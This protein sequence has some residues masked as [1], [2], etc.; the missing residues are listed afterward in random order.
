MRIFLS[1]ASQDREMA[2]SIYL[3]LRDQRHT[4]FFDRADLPAGDEYHNRI[5]S[6]IENSDL[7]MFLISANAVDAGSYTLTELSI[8]EKALIKVLPVVLGNVDV[9][10]LPALLKAV[11]FFQTDGNLPAAVAAEVYRIAKERRRRRLKYLSAA[12]VVAL[13]VVGGVFYA[14]RGRDSRERVGK[15]GAS[16]VL[17][18][19]GA[20]LGG[21]DENS[22]RRELFVEAFYLDRYEVT[23]GRYARFL[24]ATGNVRP[25]EEWD[26]VDLNNGTDLPVIGVDWQDA[27]SYCQW[28]GR[29]L[30]TDAEWERAARG[31][32]ERK[33]PWGNEPP[34]P[35]H[36]RFAQ[37]YEKAVY[38]GGVARVGSH[39]KGASPFGI[40]DMAGNA[41][42]WTADWFSES[43]PYADRR[44]PKGPSSGTSKVLR[45]GGWYD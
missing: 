41:W 2:K 16:A 3:A 18:P 28:V 6:A 4:V 35:E 15:D 14:L 13:V 25:P 17:I 19:A 22:P 26:T 33:Y 11:T 39:R 5:R 30:P 12:L 32:D 38:K 27:N 45:G 37:K 24:Q 7:F 43:F 21:D 42:E 36:A 31:M 29:R 34:T 40:H 23:V 8:A 44:N 1:Y 9:E 10:K 20:F